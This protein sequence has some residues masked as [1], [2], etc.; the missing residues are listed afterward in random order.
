MITNKIYSVLISIKFAFRDFNLDSM[1]IDDF[2]KS[3]SFLDD[4][5]KEKLVAKLVKSSRDEIYS[6]FSTTFVFQNVA[7]YKQELSSHYFESVVTLLDQFASN[8]QRTLS[9]IENTEDY[10]EI[11]N[12]V[13]SELKNLIINEEQFFN[14]TDIE[15]DNFLRESLKLYT[16]RIN[17]FHRNYIL[18]KNIQFNE[19][20][21]Q[22]LKSSVDNNILMLMNDMKVFSKKLSWLVED[23]QK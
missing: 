10:T 15:K 11:S 21:S 17:Q 2:N 3:L 20:T 4:K 14:M 22:S 23:M 7:Y 6:A 12:S 19:S 16:K 5:Q 9:R 13:T 1:K 8:L 18:L